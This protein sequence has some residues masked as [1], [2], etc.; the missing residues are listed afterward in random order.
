MRVIP[1]NRRIDLFISEKISTFELNCII[2]FTVESLRT[3]AVV[4]AKIY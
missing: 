1:L 3:F 2:S 4:I